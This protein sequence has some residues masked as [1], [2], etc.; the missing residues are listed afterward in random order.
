LVSERRKVQWWL[1]FGVE[2]ANAQSERWLNP[3]GHLYLAEPATITID[4]TGFPSSWVPALVHLGSDKP[5]PSTF[6]GA[7]T[8]GYKFDVLPGRNGMQPVLSI[9][10]N[11]NGWIRRR[12]RG[13]ITTGLSTGRSLRLCR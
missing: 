8:Y 2:P 1:V 12:S 4:M 7:A 5:V 3:D 13:S 6:N 10:Y 11:S 9:S